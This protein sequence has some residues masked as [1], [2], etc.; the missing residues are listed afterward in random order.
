MPRS[1][2]EKL[3]DYDCGDDLPGLQQAQ[4]LSRVADTWKKRDSHVELLLSWMAKK[5]MQLPLHPQNILLFNAFLCSI[6][7]KAADVVR[8]HAWNW[9]RNTPFP[10][11][12]L[13]MQNVKSWSD[14]RLAAEL[15][16]ERI[17][18]SGSSSLEKTIQQVESD[19]AAMGVKTDPTKAKPPK[20]R[21]LAAKWRSLTERQRHI[22]PWLASMGVRQDTFCH[23]LPGDVCRSENLTGVSIPADKLRNQVGRLVSF[24]CNCRRSGT[25]SAS[26]QGGAAASSA[27][28]SVHDADPDVELAAG[29]VGE[30]D[31]CLLHGAARGLLFPV[32]E[33]ECDVLNVKLGTSGHG[34]R[35]ALAL[36]VRSA[37]EEEGRTPAARVLLRRFGW[38]D[39]KRLASYAVDLKRQKPFDPI[40]FD[41]TLWNQQQFCDAGDNSWLWWDNAEQ[42]GSTSTTIKTGLSSFKRI[43]K[44]VFAKGTKTLFGTRV[45]PAP[46]TTAYKRPQQPA[47][48]TPDDDPDGFMPKR[49]KHARPA[50]TG[51]DTGGTHAAVATRASSAA[52]NRV[53]TARPLPSAAT[54]APN[55]VGAASTPLSPDAARHRTG[56]ALVRYTK[57]QPAIPIDTGTPTAPP[58]APPPPA[59]T[60]APAQRAAPPRAARAAAPPRAGQATRI[61][62]DALIGPLQPATGVPTIRI[63]PPNT[64]RRSP[65]RI[66]LQ[67]KVGLRRP[68][69]K[70]SVKQR[71]NF[72]AE[73]VN[74]WEIEA[75]C[76]T[77]AS[78]NTGTKR[79]GRDRVRNCGIRIAGY[80]TPGAADCRLRLKEGRHDSGE[81]SVWP[82]GGHAWRNDII[83]ESFEQ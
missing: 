77:C 24:G 30:T 82:T 81:L 72:G 28:G 44:P 60:S 27:S 34:W 19:C 66:F 15:A 80:C 48:P 41:N 11:E 18:G 52:P 8:G 56:D 33:K 68:A 2:K 75:L 57:K 21:T 76:I 42:V 7:F 12:T 20:T 49:K 4:Q 73:K 63:R 10:P 23:I 36:A 22:V 51:L 29:G 43:E 40:R 16:P 1:A 58:P 69:W 5:G 17:L 25:T 14:K 71:K 35:R 70:L 64:R 59:T 65:L 32:S 37:V 79:Q 50:N 53:G 38:E 67:N 47:P 74:V 9:L 83:D 3:E 62:D 45:V 61:V 78:D 31:L 6:E 55:R 39:T 46:T 54:A 13:L 26:P